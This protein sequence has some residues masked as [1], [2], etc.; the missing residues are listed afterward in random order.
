MQQRQH[1]GH[2]LWVRQERDGVADELL[3]IGHGGVCT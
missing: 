1:A 2:D 3:A